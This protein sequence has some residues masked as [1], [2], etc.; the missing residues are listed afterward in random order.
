M[1]CTRSANFSIQLCSLC[2]KQYLSNTNSE[3]PE[4]YYKLI[5]HSEHEPYRFVNRQDVLNRIATNREIY[6]LT[7]SYFSLLTI[8]VKES[9][10]MYEQC[11]NYA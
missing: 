3:Y 6:C 8:N 9:S 4:N 1:R 7:S 5:G 10:V 11:V 2:F